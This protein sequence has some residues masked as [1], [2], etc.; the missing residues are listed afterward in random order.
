MAECNEG[1]P[2]LTGNSAKLTALKPR[3]AFRRISSAASA[4][5]FSHGICNGMTRSGWRPAQT[6]RCQSF[7]ARTQAR[8][9]SGS[10]LWE[11]TAPQNPAMSDGK[12]SD[13]QM[14]PASMSRTRSSMS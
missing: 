1:S 13:A 9:S 6:S 12:H 10:L 14:P 2:S 11:N 3:A 5:S 8:P 7:H 4:G